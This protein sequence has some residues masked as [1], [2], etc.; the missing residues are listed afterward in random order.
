M[1]THGP[2]ACSSNTA[3]AFQPGRRKSLG[4]SAVCHWPSLA[5]GY[6]LRYRDPFCPLPVFTGFFPFHCYSCALCVSAD[7]MAHGWRS[8]GNF[9][10]SLLPS[11]V[12]GIES[13][14]SGLGEQVSYLLSTL[15]SPN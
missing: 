7:A 1:R 14:L 4:D 5:V 2:R 3:P 10:E 13:R 11:Q 6:A 15:T 9:Q 12:L 8:E